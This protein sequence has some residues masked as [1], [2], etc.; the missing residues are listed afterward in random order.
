MSD[1]F[2]IE[3]Y[4]WVSN[5]GKNP[6]PIGPKIQ[7]LTG[8]KREENEMI[9]HYLSRLKTTGEATYEETLNGDNKTTIFELPV[10]GMPNLIISGRIDAKKIKGAY[11]MTSILLDIKVPYEMIGSWL[12]LNKI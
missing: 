5:Q 12:Q 3:V 8:K 7:T 10:K 9:A 2:H 1:G 6:E 11:S 4:S